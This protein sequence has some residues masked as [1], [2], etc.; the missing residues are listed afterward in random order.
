[1]RIKNKHTG[2]EGW[3]SQYNPSTV[4]PLEI[5]VWFDDGSASSEYTRDWVPADGRPWDDIPDTEVRW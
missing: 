3:T 5:I 4:S 2:T 1:M